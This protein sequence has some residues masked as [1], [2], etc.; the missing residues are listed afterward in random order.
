MAF[1]WEN[2]HHQILGAK[3]IRNEDC[4]SA[5]MCSDGQSLLDGRDCPA[6]PRL[7]VRRP[8][9]MLGM[10]LASRNQVGLAEAGCIADCPEYSS[11]DIRVPRMMVVFPSPAS[12]DRCSSL[13]LL[14]MFSLEFGAIQ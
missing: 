13:P 6:V 14:R 5:K 10:A 3:V 7:A 11:C 1:C 2:T 9:R 8:P 4:Q 12:R